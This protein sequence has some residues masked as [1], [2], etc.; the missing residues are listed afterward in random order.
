MDLT[1]P[2]LDSI[3]DSESD[4]TISSP[5]NQSAAQEDKKVKKSAMFLNPQHL[6][7]RKLKLA[8][9]ANDAI[10]NN[11][12]S[13]GIMDTTDES[14]CEQVNE[15]NQNSDV[16]KSGMEGSNCCAA[17]NVGGANLSQ[18]RVLS[19]FTQTT[20]WQDEQSKFRLGELEASKSY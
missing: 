11:S 19:S 20:D 16:I 5:N 9:L 13:S 1:I 14:I 4:Q 10:D 17:G 15:S 12:F 3:I 7:S 18:R 6:N 2:K 8:S